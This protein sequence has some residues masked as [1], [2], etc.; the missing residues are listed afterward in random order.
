MTTTADLALLK[1]RADAV[2]ARC[3]RP[4]MK[5]ALERLTRAIE[6]VEKCPPTTPVLSYAIIAVILADEEDAAK[7]GA[8]T[9][10]TPESERGSIRCLHRAADE[11]N[12]L[13]M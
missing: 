12:G 8:E 3:T 4:D 6:L 10:Y 5:E 2:H 9:V 11:L 1:P 7:N 13:G